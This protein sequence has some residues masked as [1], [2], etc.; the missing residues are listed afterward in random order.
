MV[1]WT[2]EHNKNCVTVWREK[3][4]KASKRE[5]V[6]NPASFLGSSHL[7]DH[8]VTHP[9]STSSGIA[10]DFSRNCK[11]DI[12]HQT[13]SPSLVKM[14]SSAGRESKRAAENSA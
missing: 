1:V 8:R 12:S 5:K 14:E 11:N 2:L 13:F 7:D 9:T 6:K 4:N 10:A 3:R